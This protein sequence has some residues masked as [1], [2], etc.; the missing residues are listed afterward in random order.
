MSW[1]ISDGDGDLDVLS[2]NAGIDEIGESNTL[3]LNNG[4]ALETN[5]AWSSVPEN[6]TYA[7]ALRA[8]STAT[9]DLDV[10]QRQFQLAEQYALSQRGERARNLNRLVIRTGQLNVESR[11]G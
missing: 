10:H 7:V 6:S 4:G 3:Y 9:V 1:A 5:P 11:I 2:G 8:M